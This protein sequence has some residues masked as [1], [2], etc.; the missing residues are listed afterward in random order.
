MLGRVR[1]NSKLP[2]PSIKYKA[3]C[4]V[5]DTNGEWYKIVFAPVRDPKTG[6]FLDGHGAGYYIQ[7]STFTTVAPWKW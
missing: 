4:T 6:K 2:D 5:K 1:N 3:A 7:K